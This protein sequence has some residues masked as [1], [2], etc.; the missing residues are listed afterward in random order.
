[1]T[2][3]PASPKRL[4]ASAA[5]AGPKPRIGI[6]CGDPAGIGPE[7][8]L[9]AVA[10]SRVADACEPILYGPSPSAGGGAFAPGRPTAE[11]GRAAYDAIVQASADAMHGTIAGIAT[12][13]ISKE[14]FALAGLP[15]R[16]HTELLQHLTGAPRV[17][18]LF[19]ADQLTVTLATIH[20]PISEVSRELTPRRL[21]DAIELT[22]EW[23]PGIGVD[24]PRIAVAGLNPHAGEAGLIGSEDRDVIAPVVA[25]C[26]ARGLDVT[27]PLPADSL[28]ARWQAADQ[29]RWTQ[30]RSGSPSV[31]SFDAVVACYHD[32]GL[33]PVKLLGFGRAV[34]VTLGLP[35]VRTSVDHGT[36]YDIAG[37][38]MA[39]HSSL[40]EAIL[41]AARLARSRSAVP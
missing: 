32:Q 29:R 26:R 1:M 19:H 27:G 28:F 8:A 24:R 5:K 33:I 14:A 7:I 15:W 36:A 21:Q 23:L 4:A 6:T 41:L 22:A 17:A 38:G 31:A 35:I 16:G 10:D 2:P 18:M 20:V 3:E 39:D 30:S 11:S 37:R 13:P 25:A 34:N 40:V 12:A 9:K